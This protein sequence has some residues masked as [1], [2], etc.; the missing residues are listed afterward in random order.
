MTTPADG[1]SHYRPDRMDRSKTN[2]DQV[3]EVRFLCQDADRENFLLS[4]AEIGYEIFEWIGVYVPADTTTTPVTP[5]YYTAGAYDHPL[6][7]A[8]GCA[9]RIAAKFTALPQVSADGVSVSL[10]TLKGDY[11]TLAESLKA[12][13]DRIT[14]T[15]ATV[16]LTNLLWVHVFDP[17]IA[18][19]TFGL[20]MMDNPLAG[21]QDYGG[22]ADSPLSLEYID[23]AE[24]P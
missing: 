23:T 11:K 7:A 13:Y 2:Y 9:L 8:H 4:D 14:A 3:S 15:G 20:G 19:T 10:G 22:R 12:E 17:E 16:D 21:E 5:G 6:M 24:G 1:W 18:P